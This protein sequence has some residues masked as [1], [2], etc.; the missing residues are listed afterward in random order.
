MLHREKEETIDRSLRDRNVPSIRK[1][2]GKEG[3]GKSET[4][5]DCV[6]EEKMLLEYSTFNSIKK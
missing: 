2:M 3:E 4:N 6:R 5:Q 1:I